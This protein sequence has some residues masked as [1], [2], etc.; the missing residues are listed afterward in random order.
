VVTAEAPLLDSS[1]DEVLEPLEDSPKFE[2][3][4]D[5][6]LGV[7]VL[8]VVDDPVLAEVVDAFADP[9]SV[10]VVAVRLALATRAGS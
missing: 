5:V 1:L 6:V 10:L 2:P 9:L 3:V 4:D 8:S 7:G